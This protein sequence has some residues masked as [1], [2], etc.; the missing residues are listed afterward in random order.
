MYGIALAGTRGPVL[1]VA[2][3]AGGLL[4]NHLLRESEPHDIRGQQCAP[5]G[6]L[7]VRRLLGI[8]VRCRRAV[9]LLGLRQKLH[10][11]PRAA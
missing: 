2:S 4:E 6:E 10:S 3:V 7:K 9:R 8:S 1:M 11:V 5:R